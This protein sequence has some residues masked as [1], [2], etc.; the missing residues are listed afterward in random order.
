MAWYRATVRFDLSNP[1][2]VENL[3]RFGISLGKVHSAYEFYAGG[4][5]IGRVGRLPPEPTPVADRVRI[6]EIPPAAIDEDGLLV[7]AVR[8][9]R[10]ETLGWSS[11]AGMYEGNFLLGD[12]FDLVRSV[13]FREAIT[14]LL[15]ITY[16]VFGIYHLY[17]YARNRKLSE[18]LWFGITT[19]LVGIY[20]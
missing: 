19:L 12:T 17:L 3:H 11:T 13:Y 6:Y 1:A 7:L 14:L 2:L 8:V 4:A 16:F 10:D 5:L 15:A 20:S 18:F 9:W